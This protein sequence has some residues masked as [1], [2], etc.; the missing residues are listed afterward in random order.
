M[1]W[2][3]VFAVFVEVWRMTKVRKTQLRTGL[4]FAVVC[5]QNKPKQV[6]RFEILL[7]SSWEW[8]N[9]QRVNLNSDLRSLFVSEL[10]H[11]P[12]CTCLTC[13]ALKHLWHT[14]CLE[15]L[16]LFIYS[17]RLCWIGLDPPL[18]SS[19]SSPPAHRCMELIKYKYWVHR[20]CRFSWLS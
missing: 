18:V 7:P 20:I 10:S 3:V 17:G 12:W 13:P 19:V 11:W 8:N 4:R 14:F 2:G 1:F 6:H 5:H 9:K 16:V 15:K